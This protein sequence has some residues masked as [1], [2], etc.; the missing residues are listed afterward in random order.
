MDPPSRFSCGVQPT[1][2]SAINLPSHDAV[3][4]SQPQP[5][6]PAVAVAA[7]A[8]AAVVPPISTMAPHTPPPAAALRPPQ[9]IHPCP[10][11]RRTDHTYRDFSM[12]NITCD[13]TLSKRSTTNFPA[14]LHLI[15]SDPANADIITWMPHGRSWKIL[16]QYRLMKEVVSKYFVQTKYESFRRQ[17]NGWGFKRLHQSG[18]DSRSYYN[19]FFLRGLPHLTHLMKRMPSHQGRLVPHVDGEPN[20]YD[21]SRRL[22]LPCTIP[23][24]A[25][26]PR[27][28]AEAVPMVPLSPNGMA[29][30]QHPLYPQSPRQGVYGYPPPH[31]DIPCHPP[32]SHGIPHFFWAPYAQHAHQWMQQMHH[33]W[34][35]AS[36][37]QSLQTQEQQQ[38][39][40]SDPSEEDRKQQPQE[41]HQE[42]SSDGLVEDGDASGYNCIGI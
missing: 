35:E 8:A 10:L 26:S 34:Y 15:I 1:S 11:P 42:D 36:R 30:G 6:P 7:T 41:Q 37:Q 9:P 18:P 16:D 23:A 17:I 14:K 40:S 20:F 5:R 24:I 32:P 25:A 33:Q 39:D 31:P 21:M 2:P 3:V 27:M 38:E 12:H 28:M 13:L 19:E 29:Q 4:V 22:P